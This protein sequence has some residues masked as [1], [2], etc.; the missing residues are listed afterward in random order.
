MNKKMSSNAVSIVSSDSNHRPRTDV[1]GSVINSMVQLDGDILSRLLLVQKNLLTTSAGSLEPLQ[2]QT[3]ENKKAKS[4]FS[5]PPPPPLS[6]HSS[7]TSTSITEPTTATFISI[8]KK[9]VGRQSCC[10]KGLVRLG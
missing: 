2:T 10:K 7:L 5:K 6:P 3:T 4:S 8:F 1:S 9:N